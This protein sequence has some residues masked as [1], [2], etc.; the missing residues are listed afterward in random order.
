[1]SRV[2]LGDAS[3]DSREGIER[4]VEI[5]GCEPE[6]IICHPNDVGKVLRMFGRSPA[7]KMWNDLERRVNTPWEAWFER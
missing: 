2:S 6:H 4:L 7:R 1:M 5:P 3:I